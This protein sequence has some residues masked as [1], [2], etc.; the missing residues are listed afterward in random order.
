MTQ[1]SVRATAS[2]APP[3]C[4]SLI[5]TAGITSAEATSIGGSSTR[6]IRVLRSSIPGP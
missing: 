5:A 3:G 6:A 2:R 4:D 1:L